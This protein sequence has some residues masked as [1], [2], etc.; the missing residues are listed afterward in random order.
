MRGDC[1]VR[2]IIEGY[3]PIVQRLKPQGGAVASEG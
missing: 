2:R 3:P 1:M